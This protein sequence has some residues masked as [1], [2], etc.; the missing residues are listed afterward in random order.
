MINSTGR[1]G[2]ILVLTGLLMVVVVFLVSCAKPTPNI[3]KTAES[4]V[5]SMTKGDFTSASMDFNAV[6]KSQLPSDKLGQAWNQLTAQVGPFKARTGT[7]EAQEQGCDVAY[8]TCQFEKSNIDIKVV[9]DN[10]KQVT[11]LFM[12]PSQSPSGGR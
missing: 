4:I 6:M 5:D 1:T 7:Q 3:T 8:V 9:F 12:I 2:R 10:K 11:G